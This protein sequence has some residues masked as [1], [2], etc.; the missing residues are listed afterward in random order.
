MNLV[1]DDEC[2]VLDGLSMSPTPP[3]VSPLTPIDEWYV[4]CISLLQR[5]ANSIRVFVVV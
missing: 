3:P 4:W 5:S 1:S 2:A